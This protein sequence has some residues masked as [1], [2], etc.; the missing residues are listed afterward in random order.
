MHDAY[1]CAAMPLGALKAPYCVNSQYRGFSLLGRNPNTEQDPL[2]HAAPISPA[3]RCARATPGR[4]GGASAPSDQREGRRRNAA[5]AAKGTI[6]RNQPPDQREGRSRNAAT[7]AKGTILGNQLAAAIS[8]RRGAAGAAGVARWQPAP[9]IPCSW[10]WSRVK[11]RIHSCRAG[12]GIRIG[13]GSVARPRG[14]AAAAAGG[15]RCANA[16]ACTGARGKGPG[17]GGPLGHRAQGGSDGGSRARVALLAAL[18]LMISGAR[19]RARASGLGPRPGGSGCGK[20]QG[21]QCPAPGARPGRRSH[22]DCD[23]PQVGLGGWQPT[24]TGTGPMSVCWVQS[25]LRLVSSLRRT[26]L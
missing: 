8:S 18:V 14:E 25:A 20:P 6:A 7:A 3:A 4:S 15:C 17:P 21:A 1:L 12:V 16:R 22:P 10:R 9:R 26:C 11:F 13:N 2:N 19:P 23:G 5:A 24:G